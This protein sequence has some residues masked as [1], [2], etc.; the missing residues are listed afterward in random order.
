VVLGQ[1]GR[2][3]RRRKKKRK[4]RKELNRIRKQLIASIVGS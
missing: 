1:W 3:K 4:R 2:A